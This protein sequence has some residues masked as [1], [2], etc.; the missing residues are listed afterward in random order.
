MSFLKVNKITGSTGTN[1]PI[2]STGIQV[3][4]S[5]DPVSISTITASTVRVT[6]VVTAAQFIGNG[7]GLTNVQ[8]VTPGK[9]FAFTVIN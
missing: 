6:G 7:S 2:F 9:C 4:E 8:G 3:S 5:T 1:A